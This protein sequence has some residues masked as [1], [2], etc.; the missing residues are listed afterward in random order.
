MNMMD[1]KKWQAFKKNLTE[2]GAKVVK[3]VLIGVLVL[4]ICQ[5]ALFKWVNPP[6][7]LTQWSSVLDGYT[8][9]RDTTDISQISPNLQLAVIAAEDQLFAQHNGFD[10]NGIKKAFEHNTAGKPLRGAST[11]SQ[12]TAKNVFLWQGRTWLRKGLE[13]YFTFV[14]EKLYGKER[15]LSLYLNEAEMGPGIFGAEAAAHAYFNKSAANLT[16]REAALIAACLPNPKKYN[17]ARPS[18]HIQRK[19]RWILSQMN[20]LKTRPNTRDLLFRSDSK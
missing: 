7:T 8:F 18:S 17:P 3:T 14:I 13:V 12:Q 16:P 6:I 10:M 2:N 19:A 4:H 9:Q 1:R 15:I 5:I 11:I 20:Y